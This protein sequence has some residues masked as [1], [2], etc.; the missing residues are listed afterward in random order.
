MKKNKIGLFVALGAVLLFAVFSGCSKDTGGNQTDKTGSVSQTVS[1]S[2][3]TSQAEKQYIH[4][5]TQG[6]IIDEQDGSPTFTYTQ[7]CERC[8][9]TSLYSET[10]TS[11]PE[12]SYY[13]SFFCQ[14]CQDWQDV[15]VNTIEK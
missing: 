6:C 13:N 4:I 10:G 12:D 2:V 8:G 1:S 3:E 5:A 7:K 9:E 11:T 15:E 14:N